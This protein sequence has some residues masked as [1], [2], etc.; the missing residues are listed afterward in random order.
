[1]SADGSILVCPDGCDVDDDSIPDGEGLNPCTGGETESCDDNCP[2]TPN[3]DQ[4]HSNSGEDDDTVRVGIQHYG[5]VCDTDYNN[6]GFVGPEDFNC[7]R[8]YFGIVP[9]P[10]IGD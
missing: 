5:N 3:P 6:N 4:R 8:I 2:G 1:M 10:G 7:L 9:G